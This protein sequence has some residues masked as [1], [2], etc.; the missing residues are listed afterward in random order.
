MLSQLT[1]SFNCRHELSFEFNTRS[2][3]GVLFYLNNANNKEF[4]GVEIASGF[5]TYH[6]KCRR[7]EAVLTVAAAKVDDG[8]WHKVCCLFICLFFCSSP[9]IVSYC[10]LTL[11][12]YLVEFHQIQYSIHIREYR[13]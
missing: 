7:L 12:C 5:L 10:L 2:M 4:V 8:Q 1:F 3:S 9:L 13:E 6:I 11:I